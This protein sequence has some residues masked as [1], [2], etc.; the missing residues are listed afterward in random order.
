M[1]RTIDIPEALP[2]H[3]EAAEQSV[4]GS[5]LI[6]PSVW[7][8][9]VAGALVETDFFFQEH[10][11]IFKVIEELIRENVAVDVVTVTEQLQ[12]A[13]DT[14]QDDLEYVGSLAMNT[15]AAG[16]VQHYARIVKEHSL[17]RSLMRIGREC[18]RR[19]SETGAN[20]A[21][22]KEVVEK[23][24]FGLSKSQSAEFV[25]V[26]KTLIAA[27]DT[28]EKHSESHD[29]VTGV[30]TGLTDLDEKTAGLQRGDLII[31][32]ARPSMGKTAL[33]MGILWHALNS[34]DD[35]HVQFYSMEMPAE[36]IIFRL[37]SQISHLSIKNLMQGKLDSDGWERLTMALGKI[38]A[39][40]KRL[41]LDDTP[42]LSPTVLR[43]KARRAA[44]R[45]G[46]PKLI[47]VDYLQLMK[48]ESRFENR[49]L[50]ITEISA[51]LKNIA[52]EMAC[53]VLA[54]SQLNRSLEQRPNKRPILSDLRDSGALEQD[55]DLITFIYRDEVYKPDSDEKGTAEIIIGK[56]RNGPT[57]TVRAAFLAEQARFD[58][59]AFDM[60]GRAS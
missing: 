49:N 1:S 36:Q 28:I 43:A 12:K 42:G 16:N 58:N 24:L 27:I 6:D 4:L 3:S 47:V 29:P 21:Q 9:F 7:D 17:L 19:A 22:V 5:L 40:E 52:K 51:T 35:G 8:Q 20:S 14:E 39:Q 13:K 38:T 31:L 60:Y 50:E 44:S 30:A 55:A 53:P 41:I 37:L 26:N 11:R 25:D 46:E 54:L 56:H 10:R 32:A 15:P 34:T 57:G 59:L 18:T 33:A 45:Q 23:Q 48:S 2:P